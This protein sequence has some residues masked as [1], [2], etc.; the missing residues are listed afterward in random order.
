MAVTVA[1]SN[2][3]NAPFPAPIQLHDHP[4]P[5][6]EQD[7]RAIAS[8]MHKADAGR[9]GDHPQSPGGVSLHG[10]ATGKTLRRMDLGK[11]RQ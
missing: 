10:A 4:C 3:P 9:P 1:S 5:R 7:G 11:L 2:P 6:R 8:G